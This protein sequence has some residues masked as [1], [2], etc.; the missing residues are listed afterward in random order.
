MLKINLLDRNFIHQVSSCFGKQQKYFEWYRNL[1]KVSLGA[2]FT[3]SCLSAV[4][5][6][7]YQYNYGWLLE[8]PEIFNASYKYFFDNP[9]KFKRKHP[10]LFF[11][12][13]SIFN[14]PHD[15]ITRNIQ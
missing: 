8:P 6:T 7:N 10:V 11:Y 15:E 14:Q 2:F 12:L 13:S 4:L 3:D 5:K 1:D 9:I